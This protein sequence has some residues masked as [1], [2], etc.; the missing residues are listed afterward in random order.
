MSNTN[1]NVTHTSLFSVPSP[2]QVGQR[3]YWGQLYGSSDALAIAEAAM[4]ADAPVVVVTPDTP[5]AQRL[6]HAIAFFCK[7]AANEEGL[8]V[9]TFPDWETLP[10]DIFSPH[11]DII[12]DRLATLALLPKLTRGVLIVPVATL[13]HRLAPTNFL[14]G[15]SFLIDLGQTLDLEATRTR[16]DSA[17]YRCVSQGIEPG[18]V[19]I[20]GAHI[21]FVPLGPSTTI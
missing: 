11:Q 15:N 3:R 19:R 6:E 20:R 2:Q 18:A 14:D 4:A 9:L 17:G 8:P 1:S 16:L 7:N 13:L 5:S 10:Y 12:S 21:H